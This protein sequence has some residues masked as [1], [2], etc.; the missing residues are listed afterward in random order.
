[1]EVVLVAE[2]DYMFN[3][4]HNHTDLNV[5]L[6]NLIQVSLVWNA[7]RNCSNYSI[8]SFVSFIIQEKNLNGTNMNYMQ[9]GFK[10]LVKKRPNYLK[11]LLK[12]FNHIIYT[13]VDTIWFKD[14]R[15]F[16]TG[17][18]DFWGQIDGLIHRKPFIE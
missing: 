4:Y 15:P 17:N 14:P 3:K 2:D 1:M 6:F 8:C 11:I 10:K 16:F 7:T 13:D 5:L 12:K 9:P 18:Y